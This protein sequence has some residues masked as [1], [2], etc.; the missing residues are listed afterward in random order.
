MTEGQRISDDDV[1]LVTA[2]RQGDLAA[3]EALV[4][5][6]QQRML[7]VAYRIGGDYDDAC[8]VVQDAFVAAYRGLAGFRGDARFAT[9]LTTVVLN[10]ART[11]RQQRQ[12]QLAREPYSLDDPDPG[13]AG[14]H[15]PADGSPSAHDRLERQEI[16]QR[17]Q[18][19]IGGLEVDY[20]EVLV[21]RDMQEYSYGEIGGMLKLREGTV[22]SRLYRAREAVKDCLKRSMGGW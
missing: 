16:R 21:L 10:T 14:G 8:D 2:S 18:D 3:F 9:W 11:R 7:T 17:V 15:D 1:G 20:R 22:K 6:Y 12:A 4:R 13:G 5:K 19:C